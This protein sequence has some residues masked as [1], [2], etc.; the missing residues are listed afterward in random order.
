MKN[1]TK[2]IAVTLFAISSVMPISV[3]EYI[4]KNGQPTQWGKRFLLP[5]GKYRDRISLNLESQNITSLEGLD[6]IQNS[7]FLTHLKLHDNQLKELPAASF[8][9]FPSLRVLDL[10]DNQ[11]HTIAPD[12]F[13]KLRNLRQ[14]DFSNNKM[15][16]T[17]DEFKQRYLKNTPKLKK[18]VYKSD[19]EVEEDRGH[20]DVLLNNHGNLLD[21]MQEFKKS[22]AAGRERLLGPIHKK[23]QE[24]MDNPARGFVDPLS[25]EDDGNTALHIAVLEEDKDLIE[26]LAPIPGLA[27]WQNKD[28]NTPLHEALR[29]TIDENKILEMVHALLP[30]SADIVD[31]ENDAGDT[32]ITL[33]THKPRILKY[34]M[35]YG[36]RAQRGAKQLP[37]HL[38]AD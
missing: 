37:E 3:G 22:D 38:G 11:I 20:R 13:D 10:S 21:L 23:I 36:A 29:L 27:T 24:I 30:H 16:E 12:A 14:L 19:D 32:P 8:D 5:N 18:F 15:Q 35:V 33:A 9:K 31:L 34:L 17:Y 4:E 25:D 28:G 6:Q 7:Q 1:L 26:L 2:I